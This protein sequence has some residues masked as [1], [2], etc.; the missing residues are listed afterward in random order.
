[1]F[2]ARPV[3]RCL[4]HGGKRARRKKKTAS[5][6]SVGVEREDAR[7]RQ[8]QLEKDYQKKQRRAEPTTYSD[9]IRTIT[10]MINKY[11]REAR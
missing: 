7:V 3:S 10:K 4:S 6:D 11:V 8:R 5:E 1:M 9:K 2:E